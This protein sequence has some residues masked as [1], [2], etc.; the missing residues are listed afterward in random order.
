MP[1][2]VSDDGSEFF[3]GILLQVGED[4]GCEQAVLAKASS[5]AV[6]G[7]RSF[8]AGWYDGVDPSGFHAYPFPVAS[9]PTRAP[10]VEP[11]PEPLSISLAG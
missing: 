6:R 10:H 11:P 4:D 3:V 5:A 7:E 2:V 1:V 8:E 9:A